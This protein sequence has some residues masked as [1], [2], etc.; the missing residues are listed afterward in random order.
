MSE[1]SLRTGS[2]TEWILTNNLG[3]Y[4]LGFG[5]LINKRKYNGLLISSNKDFERMS[6]LSGIEEKVEFQS[7]YFFLD[8]NHYANCI[9]PNGFKHIVKTYLRPYPLFIYSSTPKDENYIILKEIFLIQKK[10]AVIIKYSNLSSESFRLILRPKFSMRSHHHINKPGIWDGLSLEKEMNNGMMALT[11]PDNKCRAYIYTNEDNIIDTNI[12]YRS[13]YYPVEAMRG[14][15]SVEDLISP[16]RVEYSLPPKSSVC[17]IV[18]TEKIDNLSKVIAETESFYKGFP[19]P[20]NHPFSKEC[21][22]L[23]SN[24]S[25]SEAFDYVS[26]RKI[27]EMA[28]RDFLVEGDHIIAGYPWFGA[29]GRDTMISLEGALFLKEGKSLAARI[30]KRY[31][32]HINNGL[33]PNTFGEGGEGLNYDSID[34]PLWF[35]LRC[36][37]SG[38]M[39][40]EYL[41]YCR[42]IIQSF[43]S[44]D[45]KTF[46]VDKDGLIEIRSGNHALTWM[47]AKV[48]NNPVTPRNGKPIEINALWFNALCAYKEMLKAQS[49]TKALESKMSITDLDKMIEKVKSSLLNFFY[50]EFLADRIENGNLIKEIR[51]NAITALSLPFDFLDRAKL[52]T[53][54]KVA[55][56]R[57]LTSYGLRTLSP[58]NPAFKQKYIGSQKLRDFAYHQGTVWAYLLL[59]YAK[60]TAKVFQENIESMEREITNCIWKLRDLFLKGE[61]ASVAEVWDGYDPYFPKGCPAQ[62]WSVFALFA[63]ENILDNLRSKSK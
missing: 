37:D 13:V 2:D 17:L 42:D 12:I 3:G 41:E 7:T 62:A 20:K 57:L 23:L 50:E 25:D 9:F 34:A 46:F 4:A 49:K 18:S 28:A 27:L 60:L 43:T 21:H 44:T 59:P 63:I 15:D 10:N 32:S 47:D 52:K 36:Y 16:A 51:P 39:N 1:I 30:L 56:D 5:N 58:D 31:G 35:V 61:I 48:Y 40:D 33:L 29:W 24:A 26:Y 8:S 53:I 55:K 45:H 11:R 22:D 14:Y 6:I 38:L 19:L 54:W